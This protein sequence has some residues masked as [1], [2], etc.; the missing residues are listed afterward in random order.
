MITALFLIG[1]L[2]LFGRVTVSLI[3]GM[4]TKSENSN[5]PGL[6]SPTLTK[7]EP[8]DSDAWKQLSW[9]TQQRVHTDFLMNVRN[10]KD[11]RA[12]ANGITDFMWI[13]QITEKTCSSCGWR[14]ALSTSEIEQKLKT[15]QLSD[16]LRGIAPPLHELCSCEL[17][18]ILKGMPEPPESNEAEFNKWL[19]DAG[20]DESTGPTTRVNN[21]KTRPRLGGSRVKK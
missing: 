7:T 15:E 6:G 4:V 14:D 18:P 2:Y 16:P 1:L 3:G 19:N 12:A 13:T 10:G 20:N 9:E 11:S 5:S 17:A 8:E 21:K